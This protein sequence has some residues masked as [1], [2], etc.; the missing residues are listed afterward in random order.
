MSHIVH[1]L[2]QRFVESLEEGLRTNIPV[3]DPTR[4]N[5]IKGYRFQEN[6]LNTPIYLWVSGGNPTDPNFRDGRVSSREMEGLGLRVPI[7]EVG[8]GHLWWRRGRVGIGCYFIADRYEQLVAAEYAHLVL[9]RATDAIERT[10]VA[11][12]IDEFGE[13]ALLA[14][15]HA[16][17]FYEG[18]G[19]TNQYV[20]RGE[21]HWQ[22]LTS[23]PM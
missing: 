23:R 19:P 18:G 17:T 16:S 11:D 14:I 10:Q 4:P 9:G 6:P 2:V 8:G 22:V 21:I 5:L 1:L 20:W 15:V 7:G 3:D 13:Q 12:L